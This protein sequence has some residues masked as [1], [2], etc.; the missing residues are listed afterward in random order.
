[1]RRRSRCRRV[2]VWIEKSVCVCFFRAVGGRLELAVPCGTR[3][4][5][6]PWHLPLLPVVPSSCGGHSAPSPSFARAFWPPMHRGVMHPPS[7]GV[8]GHPSIYPSRRAESS[9]A[10][11]RGGRGH[12]GPPSLSAKDTDRR[13]KGGT[14]SPSTLYFIINLQIYILKIVSEARTKL[15]ARL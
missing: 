12:C 8:D 11:A 5:L 1:M 2:C 6:P 14:S 9:R 3:C 10:D 7:G 13:Y 4:W 15:L